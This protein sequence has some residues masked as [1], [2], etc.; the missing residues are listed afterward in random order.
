MAT[1]VTAYTPSTGAAPAASALA[2]ISAGLYSAPAVPSGNTVV[3]VVVP[4]QPAQSQALNLA[5]GGT[6]TLDFYFN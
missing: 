2:L 6:A 3:T 1:S 4:A 5:Q